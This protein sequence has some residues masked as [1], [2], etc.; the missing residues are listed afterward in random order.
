D[1]GTWELVD[2]TDRRTVFVLHGRD[3]DARY[4]LIT[5]DQGLLLH[6]MREPG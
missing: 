4:A 6:R 5:T 2:R 1:T 3:G